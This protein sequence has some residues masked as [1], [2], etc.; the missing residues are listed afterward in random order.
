M[1]KGAWSVGR[2]CKSAESTARPMTR[3]GL[4]ITKHKRLY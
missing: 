2:Q 1:V 4:R 3:D